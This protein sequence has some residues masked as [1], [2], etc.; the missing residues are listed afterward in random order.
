MCLCLSVYRDV[1][2]KTV[3]FTLFNPDLQ[4]QDS[5]RRF[6]LLLL[7]RAMPGGFFHAFGK[8][9]SNCLAKE[10]RRTRKSKFN[11]F[12]L[13]S[14]FCAC[15][16]QMDA[17]GLTNLQ[18]FSGQHFRASFLSTEVVVYLHGNSSSRLEAC[19][20]VRASAFLGARVV[21]LSLCPS[22]RIPVNSEVGALIS[23]CGCSIEK[24]GSM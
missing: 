4:T 10:R 17:N 20:L 11:A 6:A 7:L 15:M 22:N 14:Q 18:G 16:M 3:T 2:E 9:K 21:L 12:L 23:Q 1:A 5:E 24:V 8:R 13:P 19:N